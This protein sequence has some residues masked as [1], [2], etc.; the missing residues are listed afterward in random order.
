[1]DC[2]DENTVAALFEKRLPDEE[3]ARVEAHVDACPA[4][5][6]LLGRLAGVFGSESS[7]ATTLSEPAGTPP[8]DG[9]PISRGTSVGRYVVLSTIGAGGM[10]IVFKA[11]DPELDRKV[12]LKIVRADRPSEGPDGRGPGAGQARLVREAK[13]M[14][15]LSHP[16]VVSV[17]DAGT[18]G[19][20]VFLAME[21]VD[22]L[23]L[24]EWLSDEPRD[25]RD[26]LRVFLEAGRG[27]AAAHAA[28]LV[29][30]DFKP[31][32]VLVSRRGE[33]KVTDFGLAR[34]ATGEARETRASERPG[35][36]SSGA[37]HRLPPG[38][39]TKTGTI[40]G[41]PAYMAPEQRRG[42]VADARSDQF[43]FCVALYE[44]LFH[45][46]PF[47]TATREGGAAPPR[48]RVPAV[49]SRIE[50]AVRRG[51]SEDA[52]ARYASMEELL[53]AL[54][55]ESPFAGRRVAV[56]V[57]AGLLATAAIVGFT[58]PRGSHA[59]LLCKG[60]TTKLD[61]VWD[62]GR[63]RLVK[64]AFERTGKPYAGDAFREVERGLDAYTQAWVKVH[65]DACEATRVR[66]DQSDL[67][68]SLRMVCL[69]QRLDEVKALTDLFVRG[70][71]EVV[72]RS[73]TATQALT[74]IEGCSDVAALSA[75]VKPP[76]DATVRAKVEE[77]RHELVRAKAFHDAGRYVEGIAVATSA[78]AA[79]RE[80]RYRPV[81][82]EALFRLGVLQDE[83]GDTAAAEP[84][85]REA[86][87]A[88]EAA[89][90]NLLAAQTWV[91]LV[92]LAGH[93]AEFERGEEWG[94]HAAA[95][96]ERLP[97]HPEI[98]AELA[99]ALGALFFAQGRYADAQPKLEEALAA[100]E[101]QLGPDHTSVAKTLRTLG[102]TL[103][104][105]NKDDDALAA[106]AR[107]LAIQEK[108][109]GPNH[110]D[111]AKTLNSIGTVH[112]IKGRD[113]QAEPYFRRAIAVWETTQG[114]DHRELAVPL[115]NLAILLDRR[116]ERREAL[117][118]QERVVAIWERT[119]GADH[120]NT[121]RALGNL[122]DFLEHD[123]QYAQARQ[124]LEQ[125][126]A[127]REK[128]FGPQHR[129]VARSLVALGHLALSEGKPADA[130]PT[131]LRSLAIYEKTPDVSDSERAFPLTGLGRAYVALGQ[132]VK[133]LA[134]LE[135]AIALRESQPSDDAD[136]GETRF[137]LA[138]A[139]WES[140]GDRARARR[141][142][143]GALETYTHAGAPSAKARAEVEAWLRS[144]PVR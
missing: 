120:P 24:T 75:R 97:G 25:G 6:R 80:L 89:D 90:D 27:L 103:E 93:R 1:M 12:A 101:A 53:Q 85:L 40:L 83:G 115:S 54:S 13:V 140:G 56:A 81:E 91:A 73:V 49:P 135:R 126:L 143:E 111:V 37:A 121:A 133:A 7:A 87:L 76:D 137:T 112:G 99:R 51:L 34:A 59:D 45:K 47:E 14:A 128:T 114:P 105:R 82:A 95:N 92:V 117:A 124:K 84:S 5:R 118:L 72:E 138:R 125:A 139:L 142:A 22:G 33:V 116:A 69:E 98:H 48:P 63:K 78:A 106:F 18:F 11:Y 61:G 107:A 122:G 88:A 55:R 113:E 21:L 131:Y 19:D 100:Y 20:R 104:A 64:D 141:L 65:T 136:L 119:Y 86:V 60:A 74:R 77:V 129:D 42:E 71:P 70:E 23:T 52:S 16:N 39:S 134:P 35:P 15:R 108:A 26:V 109:L 3:A 2:L 9:V 44:A 4:C 43:S 28:G 130:V 110:P 46:R 50:S 58:R 79:A 10:G 62:A 57:A 68:L 41:T 29:H 17:Y 32:N 31:D 123:G 102:D 30:R 96:L 8:A 36:P 144:H 132:A 127:I 94:R 38:A 66:G 67:V